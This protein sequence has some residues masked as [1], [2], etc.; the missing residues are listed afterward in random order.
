MS[1]DEV[2]KRR[3]YF[4]AEDEAILNELA[5]Y[6]GSVLNNHQTNGSQ[7]QIKRKVISHVIDQIDF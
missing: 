1:S 5:S 4:D 2:K 7:P 6:Y 3:A